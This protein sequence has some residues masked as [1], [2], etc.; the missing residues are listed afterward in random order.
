MPRKQSPDQAKQ[1]A[2]ESEYTP[3][4]AV[5][6]LTD[7][8]ADALKDALAETQEKATKRIGELRASGRRWRSR[9]RRAPTS[10]GPS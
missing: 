10:C 2:L 4:Y 6:G 7:A 3:L 8:L 1:S 9:P 5:A